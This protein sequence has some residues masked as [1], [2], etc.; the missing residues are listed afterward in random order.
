MDCDDIEK[1]LS[2]FKMKEPGPDLKYRVLLRAK[3]VWAESRKPAVAH[4]TGFR[5]LRN[6]TY[7]LAG[8]ILLGVITLSVKK[9]MTGK[10]PGSE[11]AISKHIEKESETKISS[12]AKNTTQVVKNEHR[13]V[14]NKPGPEIAKH[15]ENDSQMKDLYASLGIDYR[16]KQLFLSLH[17]KS[18]FRDSIGARLE[19]QKRI[20]K[21]L[22]S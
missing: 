9:P 13:A 12:A 14:K 19:Q 20:L 2:R 17:R 11:P 22:E 15:I 3:A 16:G 10:L 1:H 18:E 7:I 6:Y 21:E 8:I 4:A 5:L